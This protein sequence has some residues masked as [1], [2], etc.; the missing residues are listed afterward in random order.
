MPKKEKWLVAVCHRNNTLQAK[1]MEIYT[2]STLLSVWQLC[3][4]CSNYFIMVM[5]WLFCME[6]VLELP[7]SVYGEPRFSVLLTRSSYTSEIRRT[8]PQVQ[9]IYQITHIT[10]YSLHHQLITQVM[11]PEIHRTQYKEM[12]WC[13]HLQDSPCKSQ[14]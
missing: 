3:P 2:I 5:T 10:T 7:S 14:S 13:F 11:N 4:S 9:S 12:E 1:Y 8:Q 6:P